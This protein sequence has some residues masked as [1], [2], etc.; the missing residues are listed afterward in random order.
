[1]IL[2]STLLHEVGHH[3]HATL[4]PRHAEKERVAD[5]WRSSLLRGYVQQRYRWLAPLL[6]PL[7]GLLRALGKRRS[8]S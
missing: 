3:I 6:G 8:S 4:I 7:E 2:A 5:K 1:V